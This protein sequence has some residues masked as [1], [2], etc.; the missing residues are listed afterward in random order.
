MSN[1]LLR[2]MTL[3]SVIGFGRYPELS[4]QELINLNKHSELIKMYYGLEK[5]DF[6]D[7]V[8]EILQIRGDRIIPKPSKSW[9]V[10]GANIRSMI[11]EIIA[12]NK[13]HDNWMLKK[14]KAFNKNH[15]KV[16][17]GIRSTVEDC[18][19]HNKDRNQGKRKF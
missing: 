3:R 12:I 7:E 17:S 14:E 10:Y 6:D 5:I 11:D 13:A 15:Y 16:T 8:K 4:V 9:E 18:K 19:N 2:K 1:L